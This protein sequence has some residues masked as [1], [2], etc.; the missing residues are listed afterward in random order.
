MEL[1]KSAFV[2]LVVF[3]LSVGIY[4]EKA[5][6]D[7]YRVYRIHIENEHQIK[8]LQAIG[9][10]RGGYSFWD[11]PIKVDSDVDLVVPPHKFGEFGEIVENHGIAANLSV[12]DLQRLL[13]AER[14]VTR[15]AGVHW[16]AYNTLE[17][18]YDWMDQLLKV[19]SDFL[20]PIVAGHS[21]ENCPIRGLKVSYKAGNP[22]VFMEGTTHAR[23]WIS[24][25]SITWMLNQLLTSQDENIRRVAENY[26]WYFFPVTNPDGYVYTHTTNRLWRK[27]RKP[28]TEVCYGADPN[29]NW[30][31]YFKQGGSS[32]DPCTDTFAGPYAFS[33][34]ETKSVSDYFTSI[35]ASISTYLAFHSSGQ[36]L[37]IP[38]GYTTEKLDNYEEMMEVGRKA[39]EKLKER[40]GTEYRIG[41]VAEAIYVASGG[42]IDWVKSTYD[43]PI[44]FVYELRDTGAHG[45][46]LPPEQIIPTAE[47]TL[48]SVIVILDEGEKRGLHN[49]Q[50]VRDGRKPIDSGVAD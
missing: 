34:V 21:Y 12:P 5:R 2:L 37:M 14:P 29:R 40:Y 8:V 22:G 11:D 19:H 15:K 23:E 9:N 24:A 4:G 36:L 44:V 49:R 27:T 10:L 50:S 38:Y 42:S 17:E 39:I 32:S 18:I 16:T 47:E 46:L 28:Y 30:G 6:F 26:D 20:T 31:A 45:F 7:N 13:D 1:S 33:E 3:G 41:N 43:I 35:Q 25:A 48:D